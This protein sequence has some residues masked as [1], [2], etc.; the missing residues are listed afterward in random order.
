[1]DGSHDAEAFEEN[2]QIILDAMLA[3]AAFDGFT[4]ISLRRAAAA[5]DIDRAGLKAAFPRGV[6]DLLIYWSDEL[7]QEMLD[8]LEEA[9][10][11]SMKI[12]ERVTFAV[13]T[14][15]EAVGFYR[16]AARRA[17]ATLA[18]PP[19][20][21]LAT[22]LA[23]R[24]ADRIWRGIGDT[25]TDYNFYTKRAILSGVWI[26]T[27]TKMLGDETDDLEETRSFL[28]ARIENVMQIEKL[29]AR[30]NKLGVDPLAP[31]NFLAKLRYP[32]FR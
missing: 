1:M 15:I 23:W 3:Q 12:R 14:R 29:K 31:I 32:R 7:D 21:P 19:N 16:E 6:K 30:A 20:G 10:L 17:A 11:Q 26:S 22:S 27:F 8:A 2:R 9:D 4:P 24:T 13:W 5:V 25:S 18:L 28:N